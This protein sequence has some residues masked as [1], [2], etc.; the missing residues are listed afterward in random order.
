MKVCFTA[1]TLLLK[2]PGIQICLH[3]SEISASQWNWMCSEVE[4][5]KGEENHG[6]F[7]GQS[8]CFSGLQEDREKTGNE[9]RNKRWLGVN[10]FPRLPHGSRWK[11]IPRG[12]DPRK[13][14]LLGSSSNS[15]GH[16]SSLHK[17][18]ARNQWVPL[19]LHVR[20]SYARFMPLHVLGTKSWEK[21]HNIL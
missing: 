11:C 4:S 18:N 10:F 15:W 3:T 16:R 14:L 8:S 20:F 9:K 2:K 6:S 7:P 12:L 5:G 21:W 13:Q 1:L 17:L 19:C